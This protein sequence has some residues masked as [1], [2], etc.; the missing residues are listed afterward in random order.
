MKRVASM[1]VIASLV[2]C[3]GGGAGSAPKPPPCDAACQDGVALL[4]LRDAIKLVYNL[5]LQSHPVGPQD[6]ML[7]TP[8][9]CQLGGTASVSGTAT[10]NADQGTTTVNLTYVFAQCGYPQTDSDPT[11]TFHLTLNGTITEVGTI[12]VQPST[13]TALEFTSASFSLDG[14]VYDGPPLPYVQNGC[15]LRLVQNGNNLTGT[16]CGRDAGTML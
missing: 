15:A 8:P 12:A 10:S 11:Q 7:P 1:V 2:A 5:T 13:T 4:S 14:T 9:G 6:A 16:F 3:A